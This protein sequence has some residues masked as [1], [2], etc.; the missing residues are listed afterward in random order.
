MNTCFIPFLDKQ[1]CLFFWFC[2]VYELYLPEL[3]AEVGNSQ[4]HLLKSKYSM[5]ASE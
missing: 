4:K 3:F 2:L 1:K 5:Y